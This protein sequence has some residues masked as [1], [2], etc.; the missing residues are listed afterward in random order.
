MKNRKIKVIKCPK[1]GRE[2]LPAEIFYPKHFFGKVSDIIK[3]YSGEII[4]FTG[5]TMNLSETYICDNCNTSFKVSAKINFDVEVD[6]ATNF[7]QDYVTKPEQK[8]SLFE[9]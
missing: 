7:A 1:C 9:G 6:Q 4:A 5:D 8:F 3:D 2:Y